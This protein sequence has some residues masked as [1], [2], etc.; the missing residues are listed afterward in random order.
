ARL[1]LGL[2][3]ALG[4][5]ILVLANGIGLLA[6]AWPLRLAFG[7][8][9]LRSGP[10]AA[11]FLGLL[12][13]ACVTALLYELALRGLGARPLAALG[14]LV[15]GNSL[16]RLV[17]TALP[18][19]GGF[20]PIFALVIL[21]GRAFGPRFGFLTG[22]LS[23]AV[24]AL[25]T[26]GIGPW[27]PYQMLA[28]GWVGQTAG[29][30]PGARRGVGP[31]SPPGRASASRVDPGLG[32]E[33]RTRRASRREIWALALFGAGWGFVYGLVLDLWGWTYLDG[34]AAA[35]PDAPGRLLA[36]L[37]ASLPWDAFRAAGNLVLIRVAGRPLLDAL[38]RIGR[39]FDVAQPAERR[40]ARAPAPEGA[41]RERRSRVG[42][43]PG[44]EDRAALGLH[45]RA[46]LVWALG[47]A[48]LCLGQ[49]QP[50][51]LAGL[52][53][54]LWAL[55]RGLA[56]Q[57]ADR[58]GAL[59]LDLPLGR[60]AL[61]TALLA[62]GYSAL[63]LHQ[64]ATELLRL[65]AG[66]PIVGGSIT[67]ESL[68]YGGLTG[69]RLSLMLAAFL[70]LQK[71]LS[72]R[73]L[74]GLVP[75]AFGP[76]A[77]AAS[78]SLAWLP[79]VGRQLDAIREAR[80]IRGIGAEGGRLAALRAWP[81]LA[82]PLL[83]GGLERAMHLADTLA[84]RGLAGRPD[85]SRP[86]RLL[87]AAG[88]LLLAAGWLVPELAL[89]R[90]PAAPVVGGP[91]PA[92]GQA[93]LAD[94]RLMLIAGAAA[95]LGAIA[96]GGRRQPF[97]AW[98]PARW[99]W[100]DTLVCLAAWLPL[101]LRL[102]DAGTRGDMAWSPYPALAWPTLGPGLALALL[103]PALPLAAPRLAPVRRSAAVVPLEAR[104]TDGAPGPHPSEPHPPEPLDAGRR[105]P[106]LAFEGWGFSYPGA[107]R[108]VF[109][110]VDLRLPGG[111]LSLVAGPSGAGKTTLLQAMAGLVPASSGGRVRGRLR[112]G[113]AGAFEPVGLGDR[114]GYVHGEPE[115]GFVADR[116]E[117]ELAFALEHRGL[118][119]GLI[120]ARV[121]AALEAV[122][123]GHLARRRLDSL[124]GG[125]RQRVAIA[126]ALALAPEV[127]VLDEPTSQLDDALAAGL[128][129]RL[130]ALTEA[131]RRTVIVGEHRLR[132]VAAQA[133]WMVQLPGGGARPRQGPAGRMLARY[134]QPVV[135]SA[136]PAQPG[137]PVL[138]LEGLR[139]GFGA[140]AEAP[141]SSSE[142]PPLIA[143][144][145][146]TLRAGEILALTG[147]SGVGKTTLLR[148]AVGL[149]RP[150]SGRV[151]VAGRDIAGRSVPEVCRE[152]GYLPQDP[153]D[154]LI[155]DTARGELELTLAAQGLEPVG[156]R[157]PER[158]LA[159][160]GIAELAERHPRE[161]STGQRQ[162]VALGAV[163]VTGPVLLLLDEPTRGL[164]TVAVVSLA[165]LLQ[166][167]A[168]EGAGI[169]VAT[170]DR[171][172][173]RAVHRRLD[174]RGPGDALD[175]PALA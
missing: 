115:A 124:S 1:G 20:S 97:T 32:A 107:A 3:R 136:P 64:G 149:L 128:L 54:S 68:V 104:R 41:A 33:D 135:P 166:G 66:W 69:L 55:H 52:G 18:G 108:P 131:G 17:E 24:S 167:L 117:D 170:H 156:A 144:L 34:G 84:A 120:T 173:L 90:G 113:A 9:V 76:L 51:V 150:A 168:A 40:P 86:G 71:A 62:G 111:R 23:L 10:E 165:R 123:L 74:L 122:E 77:L 133:D 7:G 132:R 143:D 27:L 163:L 147:P 102:V 158:W 142:A 57:P 154:L 81:A 139:F 109:E 48:T 96:L 129:D 112:I 44:R 85:A 19:P 21:A 61:L 157:D 63:T 43:E 101:L 141:E 46:W 118:P 89:L 162:R 6:F 25:V 13:L 82:I 35:G 99:T 146:L 116:V 174:L 172:M 49:G 47:L 8:P 114:V 80:A 161:L 125:Q 50:F 12:V 58:A 87:L 92:F 67:L 130:A 91:L 83:V 152:L 106:S 134:P 37:L 56:R 73:Q 88:L 53:L 148:L 151:R 145:D 31:D 140:R 138:E 22:S 160:L 38:R 60:F 155:A 103:G 72:A 70:G 153:S 119:R 95:M 5:A 171:R 127:L 98:R 164:D 4:P 137:A 175:P 65:P 126:A 42:G 93:F 79:S 121:G 100:R 11:G 75:R 78:V 105:G 28:A 30:L 159:R 59:G 169:L 45:P 2:D 39:R 36:Y 110:G 15:A 26:G 94:G 14:L 29:W 16:L